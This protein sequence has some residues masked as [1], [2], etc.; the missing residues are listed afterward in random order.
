M[1]KYDKTKDNASTISAKKTVNPS[2][3]VI[4]A[5]KRSVSK[6]TKSIKSSKENY[7]QMNK[8]PSQNTIKAKQL[9][10][11][12]SKVNQEKDGKIVKGGSKQKE[13]SSSESV[14]KK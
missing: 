1:D 2:Q 7:S 6:E 3:R 4:P 5:R 13:I 9:P 14:K 10:G 12:Y 11:R 8:P